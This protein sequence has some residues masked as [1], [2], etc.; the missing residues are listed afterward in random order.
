MNV[1]EQVLARLKPSPEDEDLIRET[2][3]KLIKAVMN[4][5][6]ASKCEFE[7]Y[8][9]G[10]IAKNTHL[11]DPDA[12][13]FLLFDPDLPREELEKHG[14]AIG[15]ESI[16]GREHYAEHPYIK[17]TFEGLKT[18]IVPA[19]KI[20]DSSQKMTA[21]DRTPLHTEYVRDN[22]DTKLQDHV[23]L[24]K[25]FMKGIGTYSAEA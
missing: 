9:V 7:P 23:R 4:S 2:V 25:A 16:I 19:Y 10:S 21:V 13:L 8:L 6:A 17:G 1:E 15:K 5:E 3:E 24:L 14:L 12:D 22:L 18:D 11:K 20:L